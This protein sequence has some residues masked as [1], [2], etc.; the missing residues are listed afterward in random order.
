MEN[1]DSEAILDRAFVAKGVSLQTSLVTLIN[2]HTEEAF[3]RI[4]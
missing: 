2:L 4:K 3:I 1:N